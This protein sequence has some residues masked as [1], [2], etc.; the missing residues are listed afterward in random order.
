VY[1]RI[2]NEESEMLNA[3]G[4]FG[5][6]IGLVLVIWFFHIGFVVKRILKEQ[7]ET[8]RLL[9]QMGNG[10]SAPAAGSKSA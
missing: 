1:E 2:E 6:A 9:G 7:K 8:N 10:S 4:M 5:G 3:F